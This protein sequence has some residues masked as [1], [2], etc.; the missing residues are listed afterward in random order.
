MVPGVAPM[1]DPALAKSGDR[2]GRGAVDGLLTRWASL[3]DQLDCAAASVIRSPRLPR[4]ISAPTE[5]PLALRESALREATGW[6]S[7]VRTGS[8]AGAIQVPLN[9]H[10]KGVFLRRQLVDECRDKHVA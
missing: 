6:R 1:T 7:R 8:R 4:W 3:S 2:A 9:T 10:P 5:S